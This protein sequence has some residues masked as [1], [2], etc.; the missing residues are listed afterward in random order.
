MRRLICRMVGHRW[1]PISMA[2]LVVVPGVGP[3][4]EF[5]PSSEGAFRACERC[6]RVEP[7]TQGAA[8]A[9]LSHEAAPEGR[10]E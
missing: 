6:R 2:T 7:T 9:S 5:V 4:V 3:V 8:A 10:V 1:E